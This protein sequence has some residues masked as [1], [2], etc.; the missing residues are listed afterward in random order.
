MNE[1]M[2]PGAMFSTFSPFQS[3]CLQSVCLVRCLDK[4][5]DA[6]YSPHDGHRELVVQGNG[7]V[8]YLC[9]DQHYGMAVS[10]FCCFCSPHCCLSIQLIS[11]LQVLCPVREPL[12]WS[13]SLLV[14]QVWACVNCLTRLVLKTYPTW[15]YR[16]HK[17]RC[18]IFCGKVRI[19]ICDHDGAPLFQCTFMFRPTELFLSL[20]WFKW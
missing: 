9:F 4:S 17:L 10:M 1:R 18:T 15:L 6:L 12:A 8:W 7:G 11:R 13:L 3:V 16:W 14:W 2:M 5:T 19:L 20:C